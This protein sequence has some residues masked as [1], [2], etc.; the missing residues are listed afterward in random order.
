[1]RYVEQNFGVCFLTK[2]HFVQPGAQTLCTWYIFYMISMLFKVDAELDIAGYGQIE[3]FLKLAPQNW[4]RPA[5]A[6]D[7]ERRV[8]EYHHEHEQEL[9]TRTADVCRA[10]NE[11]VDRFVTL[12]REYFDEEDLP[13][14]TYVC[15]P[16]I[17]PLVARDPERHRVAFPIN[18]APVQAS[19]VLAHE[20]L[21]ELYYRHVA[22]VFGVVELTAQRTW[23]VSE[24]L[25]VLI[26]SSPKWQAVFPYV[27]RPYA[28]HENLHSVLQ[29]AWRTCSDLDDFLRV[30]L[31]S[32]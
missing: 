27:F 30:A 23:D 14:T 10:W 11:R 25:N 6:A 32:S 22:R 15:Y 29:T 4:E 24:V 20:F 7:T 19:A 16:T 9:Q 8:K 12:A 31:P 5:D 3:P 1:M 13:N 28:I 17:W 21:H 26:M 2:A 18:L